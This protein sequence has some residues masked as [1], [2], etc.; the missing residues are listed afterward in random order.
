MGLGGRVEGAQMQLAAHM[1]PLS[2]EAAC[3]KAH[4]LR[5]R[6]IPV[7]RCV[8]AI[9]ETVCRTEVVEAVVACVRVSVVDHFRLGPGYHFVGDGSSVEPMPSPLITNFGPVVPVGV[10]RLK[11]R[12]PSHTAIPGSRQNWSVEVVF[13]AVAPFELPGLGVIRKALAKEVLWW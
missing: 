9:G 5:E 13:R 12:G 10:S 3:R 7:A 2:R 11:S 4:A 8:E 1:S 6:V